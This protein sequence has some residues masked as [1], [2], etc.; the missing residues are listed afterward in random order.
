MLLDIE[1]TV[2][3][4]SFVYDILFPYARIH[5]PRFIREHWDGE[6]LREAR[7]QLWELNKVDESKGAP[8]LSNSTREIEISAVC[9]Y[10]QWL[11]ARDSKVPPLKTIQ[12]FIWERGFNAGDL[13]SQIFADVP[14]AFSRWRD[15]G[16][17]IA[18]YSSGSALAQQQVFRHSDRG[19]LT[20]FIATYFDT[21]I[22]GKRE[23]RS[24]SAI[25]HHLG[26][27]PSAI[28]FASDVLEELDAAQSAGLATVLCVR[29]GNAAVTR[30]H[31]YK[32]VRSFDEWT[33]SFTTS[34]ADTISQ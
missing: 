11:M 32:I 30:A 21:R 8:R 22:G 3:P 34:Y 7:M 1:G 9:E 5:G 4:V 29:P 18:I 14:A 10:Y 12:G 28:L 15:Q 13:M 33:T 27:E 16:K 24:Y 31:N 25:A 23:A 20:P 19:D 6:M 17:I 26:L 2:A